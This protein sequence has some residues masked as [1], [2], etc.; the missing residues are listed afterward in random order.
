MKLVNGGRTRDRAL[1]IGAGE[2]ASGRPSDWC[3]AEST[4]GSTRRPQPA[5][6]RALTQ[7]AT[8][9]AVQRAPHISTVDDSAESGKTTA[10]TSRPTRSRMRIGGRHRGQ[11][12]DS[13]RRTSVRPWRGPDRHAP[14]PTWSGCVRG[15]GRS[16][17]EG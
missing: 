12:P 17:E 14:H 13:T 5:G 7:G 16:R 2:R 8:G 1:G 3:G 6:L 15:C 4:S 11:H 9:D 10:R